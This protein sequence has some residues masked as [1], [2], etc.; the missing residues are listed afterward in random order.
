MI[1]ISFYNIL[2]AQT[3]DEISHFNNATNSN[4][5]IFDLSTPEIKQIQRFNLNSIKEYS[6]KLDLSIPLFNV[7]AG[8]ISYPISLN[9][10]SGG[11]KVN[12]ESSNVGLG[13]SLNKIFITRKIMSSNDFEESGKTEIEAQNS[14]P[15]SSL[16]TKMGYF[17]YKSNNQELHSKLPIIDFIPD[18]Y[19]VFIPSGISSFYF[20]DL[21]T[22]QEL[23]ANEIKI[24]K[25]IETKNFFNNLGTF[26][27]SGAPHLPSK[28]IYEFTITDVNGIKYEFKE[29]DVASQLTYPESTGLGVNLPSVSTWHVT[30][31]IDPN[32]NKNIEFIYEDAISQ[33]FSVD[34]YFSQTRRVSIA[35]MGGYYNDDIRET[36]INT[37]RTKYAHYFH[38]NLN[39]L[40]DPNV[41]PNPIYAKYRLIQEFYKIKRLKKIIFPEGYISFDYNFTRTDIANNK[42]AISKIS[43]FDYNNKLIKSY[44]FDYNYFNCSTDENLG[45]YIPSNEDC[46]RLKLISVKEN[47]MPPYEFFYIEDQRL[48][49]KSSRAQDFL[50]FYNGSHLPYT[51]NPKMLI[52]KLY[53]YPNKGAWSILPFEIQ[54]EDFYELK[55]DQHQYYPQ[56]NIHR[57]SNFSYAKIGILNKINYPT[58]GSQEFQYES[59]TFKVFGETINGGGLRIEKVTLN[60]GKGNIQRQNYQYVDQDNLSSG[61]LVRPPMYGYPQGK[62]FDAYYDLN[63]Q[64]QDHPPGDLM[65]D[66]Q[67]LPN[68]DIKKLYNTFYINDLNTLDVDIN[69]ASFVGY[70]DV[71]KIYSDNSFERISFTSRIDYPDTRGFGRFGYNT[72]LGERN[73][74]NINGYHGNLIYDLL[75]GYG[76]FLQTNSNYEGNFYTDFS[77]NRGKVL[78]IKKYDS[79]SNLKSK[80]EYTYLPKVN[81]NVYFHLPIF[82]S[83]VYFPDDYNQGSEFITRI[84]EYGK[85]KIAYQKSRFTPISIKK[86]EY[87]P[88][89]TGVVEHITVQDLEYLD[90]PFSNRLSLKKTILYNNNSSDPILESYHGYRYVDAPNLP[91]NN[92][93][94][95]SLINKNMLAKVVESTITKNMEYSGGNR[96]KEIDKTLNTYTISNNIPVLSEVKKND[97]KSFFKYDN[98]GNVIEYKNEFGIPVSIVWGYN[99]LYPIAK[100]E[101]I[102]YSLIPNTL[103]NNAKTASNADNDSSYGAEKENDLRVKL[104]AFRTNSDLID[105]NVLITTYTYDPLVGITSVTNPIGITGYYKYDLKGRLLNIIDENGKELQG[106]EYNI[107]NP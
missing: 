73:G 59:N 26:T 105:A 16:N 4:M 23:T 35:S 68:W 67:G 89:N 103:I 88:T 9:Y 38:E 20:E 2:I 34:N 41:T 99:N 77:R 75:H 61:F 84:I 92:E 69:N 46:K 37:V 11:I 80:I 102:E 13:W 50:G 8:N 30:K 66:Y 95:T 25:T 14:P 107:P 71:K 93:A 18:I 63:P 40:Y 90:Q 51:T 32:S 87:L 15:F 64:N 36:F 70:S 21:N 48:P 44:S 19:N 7:K 72:D 106:F 65:T 56:N 86:T 58:G 17:K 85:A 101:G 54:G 83:K 5:N 82:S 55:D 91:Y 42:Q 10:D 33:P 27:P 57:N 47:Q 97:Q 28:N 94:I 43:L 49:R 31:I 98:L 45:N 60:D 81:E 39:D 79:N 104:N 100:I 29:Y 53:Y 52:P 76:E 3:E 78:S 24:S 12:Q 6:G 74:N 96:S 1:T 62:L 22:P